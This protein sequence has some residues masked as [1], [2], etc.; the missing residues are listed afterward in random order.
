MRLRYSFSHSADFAS[1]STAS[2]GAKKRV[3][4]QLQQTTTANFARWNT[5]PA[6]GSRSGPKWPTASVVVTR[7]SLL[8]QFEHGATCISPPASRLEHFVTRA[9]EHRTPEMSRVPLYPRRSVEPHRQPIHPA[10]QPGVATFGPL[11]VGDDILVETSDH[12]R[13]RFEMRELTEDPIVFLTKLI[14]RWLSIACG[15]ASDGAGSTDH[16]WRI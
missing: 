10:T 7:R 4:P 9:T 1:L 5:P 16:V 12:K 11:E 3:S 6:S 2:R 8:P 15:E 14:P 13:V